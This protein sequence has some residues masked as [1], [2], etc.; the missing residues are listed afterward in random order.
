MFIYLHGILWGKGANDG[1]HKLK[2]SFVLFKSTESVCL[3]PLLCL[4]VLLYPSLRLFLKVKITK[5]EQWN[6]WWWSLET[7]CQ[8]TRWRLK[9]LPLQISQH[10]QPRNQACLS[11]N[12]APILGLM[13]ESGVMFPQSFGGNCAR[14]LRST[15][16]PLCP[17]KVNA[18]LLPFLCVCLVSLF[19]VQRFVTPDCGWLKSLEVVSGSH[20][21]LSSLW[22]L[23]G[24]GRKKGG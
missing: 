14:L 20:L 19:L 22:R 23:G 12:C 10:M 16:P 17:T 13:P 11:R 9:I 4:F 6:H 18:L 2:R 24:V 8:I 3:P 5:A 1:S 7:D 15:R 21:L